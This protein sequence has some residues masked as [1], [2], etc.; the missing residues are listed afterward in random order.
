MSCALCDE[1]SVS[2][3]AFLFLIENV[4]FGE[5]RVKRISFC[6]CPLWRTRM[7]ALQKVIASNIV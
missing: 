2:V 6:G 3:V 4:P 7:L 1:I 5:V